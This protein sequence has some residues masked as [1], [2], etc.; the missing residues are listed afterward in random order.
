MRSGILLEA[1][2]GLRIFFILINV[3]VV[4]AILCL[5]LFGVVLILIKPGKKREVGLFYGKEYAHRGL[6]GSEV[7]E[8]SLTAFRLAVEA[9]YGVELDVQMTK[10]EKLVVFHDATLTRM[11]GVTGYL[12]DYTYDEL[13]TLR[14]K[15]T[16][17]RIP[18]F[19]EVLEVLGNTTLVC[20]LKPDNGAM[21][22]YFC[23]KVYEELCNYKGN[24]CMESFSPYITGWFKKHHPEIIRGQLSC[25]MSAQDMKNP[26]ARC[27]LTNM[28]FNCVSRPDFISYD[29]KSIGT[30]GYRL[31]KRVFNPFRIAWT[32]RGPEE[33]EEAKKEF[34]TI[35]F[36]KEP[37]VMN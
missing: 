8:N 17:E 37:R 25:R 21:N 12:R 4:L 5:V 15:G 2:P 19:S 20:E 33:I 1:D 9:G 27:L 36:E 32:P 22:Y 34:D 31:I 16:E 14:L 7:P 18:L 28:L 13:Q 10:D 24:Y 26:F 35:I 6:H 29:F 3:L 30:W 11:C 23:N